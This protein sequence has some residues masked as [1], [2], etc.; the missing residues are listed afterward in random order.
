MNQSRM[1]KISEFTIESQLNP[2]ARRTHTVITPARLL[3]LPAMQFSD[4]SAYEDVPASVLSGDLY[5][6]SLW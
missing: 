4:A 6:G 5:Q 2:Y 1:D 3:Q